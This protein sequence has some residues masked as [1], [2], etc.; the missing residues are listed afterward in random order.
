MELTEEGDAVEGQ[1]KMR[2]HPEDDQDIGNTEAW[3]EIIEQVVCVRAPVPAPM[4]DERGAFFIIPI[5][6]AAMAEL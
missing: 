2:K 1:R 6:H 5:A 4:P 3:A